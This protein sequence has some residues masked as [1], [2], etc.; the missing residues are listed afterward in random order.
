[1]V[2]IKIDD[3]DHSILE[4]LRENS[5]QSVKE[6]A[7]NLGMRPSTVHVRIAKLIEH[8]VIEKYT[9]KLNNK[10]VG[11]K[12]IV[13]VFVSTEKLIDNREFNH[14]FIKEVFGITGEYDLILKLKCRDIEDF[15]KF[16][17]DFRKRN[18]LRK[19]LTMVATT[20]I[21]EEI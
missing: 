16:I 17:L 12:F 14:P 20:A 13:F 3:R 1:V 19:T 10:A 21:K 4:L 11:E 6:I 8:G 7:K 2:K 5:R 18:D 9:L 15:N